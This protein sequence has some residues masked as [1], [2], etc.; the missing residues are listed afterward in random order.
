MAAESA[1]QSE[2]STSG[3]SH[4]DTSYDGLSFL[5]HMVAGSMAG[6]VEHIAM[7]P[8]DTIKTRMQALGH[9]GQRLHRL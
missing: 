6:M 9:P 4:H 8:V 3:A 1:I 5:S 2:A 7:Y